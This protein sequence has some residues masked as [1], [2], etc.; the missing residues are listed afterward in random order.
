VEVLFLDPC[1]P[2]F[3]SHSSQQ[4]ASKPLG[5]HEALGALDHAQTIT[6]LFLLLIEISGLPKKPACFRMRFPNSQSMAQLDELFRDSLQ[7]SPV[8]VRM[9]VAS[10][11]SETSWVIDSVYLL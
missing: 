4:I 1:V 11:F 3:L 9:I 2:S 8:L 6:L 5:L 10:S 7:M